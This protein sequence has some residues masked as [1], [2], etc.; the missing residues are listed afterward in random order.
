LEKVSRNHVSGLFSKTLRSHLRGA[1][2]ARWRLGKKNGEKCGMV[3][4]P[5]KLD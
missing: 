4:N 2:R 5:E 1:V 3:Q